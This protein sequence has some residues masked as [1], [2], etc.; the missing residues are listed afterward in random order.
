RKGHFSDIYDYFYF[1][2][3]VPLRA[4]RICT[5]KFKIR[6]FNRYVE[7]PCVVYIGF[8]V[9]EKKRVSRRTLKDVT[10]KYPLIDRGLTRGDCKKLIQKHGLR[11]PPKSGCYFCPFQTLREWKRLMIEHPRLFQKAVDLENNSL[12][13]G[14]LSNNRKLESLLQKNKLTQYLEA[15]S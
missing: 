2:E 11:V 9:L 12:K 10:Y 4:Y 3:S 6:P 1:Y 15:E 8:D 7:K 14:L 13:V 5:A